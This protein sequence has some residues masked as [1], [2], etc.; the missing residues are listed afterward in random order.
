MSEELPGAFYVDPLGPPELLR[1]RIGRLT[2]RQWAQMDCA[3]CR[4]VLTSTSAEQ[5]QEVGPVT[6]GTGRLLYVRIC[7]PDCGGV[8]EAPRAGGES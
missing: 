8:P 1:I 6:D 7:V 3:K 2:P 5:T 4:C